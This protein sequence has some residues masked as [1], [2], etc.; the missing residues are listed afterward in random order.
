MNDLRARFMVHTAV[1]SP[2]GSPV[3]IPV[4][5]PFATRQLHS[6]IAIMLDKEFKA[7]FNNVKSGTLFLPIEQCS[8]STAFQS[9]R[10]I[11]RWEAAICSRRIASA[12]RLNPELFGL[13]KSPGVWP[14]KAAIGFLFDGS[15]GWSRTGFTGEITVTFIAV[16]LKIRTKLAKFAKS[17]KFQPINCN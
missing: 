9:D 15:L 6:A 12:N 11:R 1:G 17:N 2:F 13:L 5:T 7:N 10:L 3:R 16:L 8:M 14:F 4:W